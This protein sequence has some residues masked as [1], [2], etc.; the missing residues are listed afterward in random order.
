MRVLLSA[1]TGLGNFVLKTP[2][3]RALHEQYPGIEIDLVFGSPWG[4]ENVL[5][6][7]H[8]IRA[9]IEVPEHLSFIEKCLLFRRKAKKYNLILLPFD[10]TPLYLYVML[11]YSKKARVIAHLKRLSG[12]SD[13]LQKVAVLT[14]PG[15]DW[16]TTLKNRHEI[17]LNLDLLSEYKNESFF[18]KRDTFVSWSQEDLTKELN[19]RLQSPYIVLQVGASNGQATPK[20]W[21]PNNF[22][23]FVE[24]WKLS[25]PE[26]CFVLVGDDGDKK[27]LQGSALLTEDC[28]IDLLGRTSFNDLCCILKGSQLAVVHDSGVM[29][30][31]DA[32]SVP[33]I[34]LYGP[35]D[36]T[37]TRPLSKTSHTLFSKTCKNAMYGLQ[38]RESLLAERY[39]RHYCLSGI[40][41]YDLYTLSKK[42]VGK[43]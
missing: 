2:L 13:I 16:I 15:V 19:N 38:E 3:I 33:L 14:A 39:E 22:Y 35:T 21:D 34:A 31:A 30:V 25:F 43:H 9:Y 4:V 29:H 27:Y 26:F 11:L 10:S 41:V 5:K 23:K 6:G 18:Y 7:S 42:I 17:D 40:S 12:I 8:F 1:Y 20:T 36:Y 37:R 32:L 28:V 24:K